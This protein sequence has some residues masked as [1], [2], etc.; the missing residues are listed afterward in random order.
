MNGKALYIQQHSKLRPVKIVAEH[1]CDRC[2]MSC[3]NSA[4]WTDTSSLTQCQCEQITL[5]SKNSIIKY[6]PLTVPYFPVVD[7]I[8]ILNNHA[9]SNSIQIKLKWLNTNAFQLN[10]LLSFT[11]FWGVGGISLIV[12]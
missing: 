10:L 9:K 2:L 3:V 1:W 4:P 6:G 11:Y 5:K 12:K 7:I 8:F